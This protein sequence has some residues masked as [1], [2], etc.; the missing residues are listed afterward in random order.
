MISPF[1][2]AGGG[3]A[4]D[5][6]LL[7]LTLALLL[8]VA[9]SLLLGK[10]RLPPL[11]GYFICGVLLAVSGYVNLQPGSPAS[12]LLSQMGNVG[13]ILLMFTIGLESSLHELMQLRK[14]GLTA[15]LGQLGFT[16][17][18]A[19]G[20]LACFGVSGT[21]L[22]LLAFL[23]ALSSTAVGLKLFQDFGMGHHPGA[24]LTLGVALLQDM[25][26]ILLLVLLPGLTK[27]LD[28]KA[29]AVETA[30]LVGKSLVFLTCAALLSRY[31]IPKMLRVVSH[32]R[33]REMFTLSVLALCA[34]IASLGNLLGLNA[35][36]GAFAAGLAVSGS[37]YSH[38]IMADAVTFR[39]FFL[40]IFFVSVGAFVD[41]PFF[42]A[43]WPALLAG[44]LG[45]LLLKATALT[46][47]GKWGGVSWRGSLLAGV[48]LAG[49]G[50]F[51][52]VVGNK[53]AD[54]GLI[55]REMIQILL[56]ETVLTLGLSPLLMRIAIPLT[57]RWDKTR[58][59]KS[60]KAARKEA[61]SSAVGQVADH[62][63]G[64]GHGQFGK[65]IREFQQHAILCG[66]GTVG[67]MV[68]EAL[69]RLEIPVIIVEL[70][71][72]TVRRLLKEGHAVL[73]ADIS[74]ADTLELAGVERASIIVITFPHVE[75]ARTAITIAKE[76]NPGIATLC[77]ARFPSEVEQLREVSPRSIIHDEREAGLEMLRQCLSVYD[78]DPSEIEFATSGLEASEEDSR[79][80]ET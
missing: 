1:L 76:R 73:F 24:R 16:T 4:E 44:A 41:I 65:R 59:G 69:V 58:P 35:A 55:S 64:P 29:T 62:A 9:F 49:V 78:R 79:P 60:L 51:A 8:A 43:H 67:H 80:A 14:T 50:E 52:I 39:D 30:G 31:G 56:I 19:A 34:G 17:A 18:L 32:S 12:T 77:R 57:R 5:R 3:G 40:T 15:G 25:A 36:L 6:F 71:A 21:A 7:I 27:G 75:L 47:A 20:I 63:S 74:Q 46:F 26:V 54:A 11:P 2:A 45:I 48:A 68:H 22:G 53:A 10:L 37:V 38:R 33:S 66:Y 28:L 13:I 61:R 70:N 42:M 72:Q 23:T